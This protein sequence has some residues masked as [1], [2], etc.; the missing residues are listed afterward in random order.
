M[1]NQYL[2][3]PLGKFP[4]GEARFAHGIQLGSTSVHKLEALQEACRRVGITTEIIAGAAPSEINAQPYGAEETYRG[5]LN[6][7]RNVRLK[8]P[9]A[10]AIGIESGS[11]PIGEKFFDRAIV[12]LL[13]PDGKE[14]VGASMDVEF[15]RDAVLRA[16]DRGFETTTAGSV[17]AEKY[18]GS[19]TD[20]HATLSGGKVSRKALIIDAIV[21]VLSQA[22]AK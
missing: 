13:T 2:E 9:N 14:F 6:R 7:A 17:I 19:E 11:I 15:P 1:S 16:K 21:D 12:V 5:A 10:V 3:S 8:D 22:L 4:E 20:P 18:G